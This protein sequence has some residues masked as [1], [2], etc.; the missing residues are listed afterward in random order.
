LDKINL[1]PATRA[2]FPAIRRLINNV[3]INPVGLDWRRFHIAV[4]PEGELI[5]CGQIKSHSDGSRELASIAVQPR[6][7]NQGVASIIIGNLLEKEEGRSVYLMCRAKLGPFYEKFGFHSISVDLMPAYF[8]RINRLMH[9]F[10]A[11]GV[12][13]NHLLVMRLD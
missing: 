10:N 1:R 8:Q 13:E 12:S 7:R 6:F 9:L 5:G 3:Q 2:D 11:T 4:T